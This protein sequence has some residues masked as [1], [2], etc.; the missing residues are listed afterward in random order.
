MSIKVP[1]LKY[2]LLVNYVS[3]MHSE[4]SPLI[5][6]FPSITGDGKNPAPVEGSTG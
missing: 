4:F 3:T 6:A 5:G 1:F 2:T